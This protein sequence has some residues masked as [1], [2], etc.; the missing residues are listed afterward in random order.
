MHASQRTRDDRLAL[1]LSTPGLI[2]LGAIQLGYCLN[3]LTNRVRV[4]VSK[5]YV[6]KFPRNSNEQEDSKEFRIL[7][8]RNLP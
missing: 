2:L 6:L 1:S 4:T 5:E 3:I 7:E 8:I